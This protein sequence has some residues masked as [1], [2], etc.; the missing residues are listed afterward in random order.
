MIIDVLQVATHHI[1]LNRVGRSI[2]RCV[3]ASH[4]IASRGEAEL[5]AQIERT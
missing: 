1:H 5:K 4:V 2:L 3:I